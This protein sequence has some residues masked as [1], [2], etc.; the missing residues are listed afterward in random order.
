MRYFS[1]DRHKAEANIRKHGIDFASAAAAFD[2][3]LAVRKL[4]RMASGG[5]IRWHTYGMVRGNVLLIIVHTA[6]DENGDEYIRIISARRT[7]KQE[8][9]YY[10]E[11]NRE[12]GFL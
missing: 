4:D 2:D 3:P 8:T 7:T 5:E 6:I 9:G 11:K 1:W 10:F 12:R